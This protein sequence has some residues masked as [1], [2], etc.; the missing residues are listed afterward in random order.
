MA[1]PQEAQELTVVPIVF[2]NLWHDFRLLLPMT[3]TD[4]QLDEEFVQ[5][6]YP[7]PRLGILCRLTSI[8][9]SSQ[10]ADVN[11]YPNNRPMWMR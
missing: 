5:N 4:I 7:W 6:P 2:A 1:R 11:P 3:L 8:A 10:H 9:V